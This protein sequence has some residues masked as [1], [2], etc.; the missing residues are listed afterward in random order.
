M[1]FFILGALTALLSGQTTKPI[2]RTERIF[3]PETKTGKYKH[4]ASITQLSNGDLYMVYYGGAGEYAV[5]TGVFASRMARGS[6]HW[7]PPK[8]IAHDPFRSLGNAVIWSAPDKATWLFYV[9]RYGETWSTSRIQAKISRDNAKTWS[10]SFMISDRE[11]DMVRGRPIVLSNGSYLLPIYNERGFDKEVVGA[12]SVSTFLM[13]KPKSSTWVRGGEIHSAN[14]NI[15]PAVVEIA[16]GHLIAYCRRGGGYDATTSGFIVRSE[17]KDGGI[18][19][20]AGENSTFPNPNAAIDLL[21]LKN[22]Y[23]VLIYNNSMNE[24]TPLSV[25]LSRDGGNTWS[26]KRDIATGPFDFAYPFAT[27]SSDGS[28]HIVYTSH[29]RTIINHAVINEAWIMET[30]K[31]KLK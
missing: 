28:I 3:G 12:D 25:T 7:S 13:L 5:D 8:R 18:S 19:W 17:S 14:G 22:G 21:R 1:N 11:G 30:N 16:P 10:D 31:D 2:F 27:Q 6:K 24:R 15:Q 4:P 23:L 20:K 9:V 29:E 26:I